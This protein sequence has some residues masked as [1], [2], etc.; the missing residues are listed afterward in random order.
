M[1]IRDAEVAGARCDVRIGG[2]I[3]SAI[4]PELLPEAGEAVVDSRGGALLPG[5][6]DHH[7]HLDAT[8]AALLSLRCGPPAVTSRDALA[9]ALAAAPGRGW[10]R[11]V[12]FHDSIGHVD[13]AWLD[14]H[15]P[16]RPVRI[17]HRGGR[18]WVLNSRAIAEIGGGAPPDGRLIDGDALVS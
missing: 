4:A 17:Q 14:A 1:L 11:G 8:A 3:I 12:G 2:G 5:L 15:G 9:Q 13:R 7:I 6:H 18:M 10:L 16:D